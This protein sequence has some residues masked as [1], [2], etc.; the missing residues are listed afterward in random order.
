MNMIGETV[1]LIEAMLTNVET[2]PAIKSRADLDLARLV[3]DQLSIHMQEVQ[4]TVGN[5]Q[6]RAN[7][8]KRL[9]SM[10]IISWAE[11]ALDMHQLAILVLDTS[12]VQHD[13]DIIRIYA[14]NQ[15]GPM[16]DIV[17]NPQRRRNPNTQYTGISQEAI[18]QAPTLADAWPQITRE[19]KGCF[20]ISYNLE[21]V[22]S[23]L[24]ENIEHYGLSPLPLIGDCLMHQ[25]QAYFNG[26]GSLKLSETCK[27]IGHT[28]PS[29]A[30]AQDRAAAQLALLKAMAQGITEVAATPAANGD[31]G[32]LDDKPF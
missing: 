6:N 20:I 24:K 15:L 11:A 16:L 22:Q 19:L 32:D 9:P 10:E 29:P 25:A 31:L 2:A 1:Q 7:R 30:L 5:L 23:R 4:K 8:L 14:A 26:Y 17:V 13:S 28:L 12:G 3:R 27:R 18:D 21:F